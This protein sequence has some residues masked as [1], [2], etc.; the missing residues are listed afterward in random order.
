MNNFKKLKIQCQGMLSPEVYEEIAY[1]ASRCNSDDLIVDCGTAGGASCCAALKGSENYKP[2]LITFDKFK[3]GSREKFGSK[4]ENI[5]LAKFNISKFD[6]FRRARIKDV[7]F[8]RNFNLENYIFKKVNLLILDMDGQIDRDII[9]FNKFL[10]TNNTV[11][12][13]DYTPG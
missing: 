2:L 6:K 11:I 9:N 5:E 7:T 12:I 3:G 10:S 8:S 13:D 4:E 1:Q